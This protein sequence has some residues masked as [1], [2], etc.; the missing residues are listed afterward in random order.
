MPGRRPDLIVPIKDRRQHKRYLT[1]KNFGLLM[2]V[3]VVLFVI[4][5][6]RSEMRG[7]K[8]GDY[9]QLFGREAAVPIEQKPIE[10][11]REAP[12][13]VD[14]ATHADPMLVTPAAR[15]QWLQDDTATTTVAPVPAPVA[16][17]TADIRGGR[18]DVAVVG[19]P[20]GVAVV[21]TEKKKPLL[22]GGF[23]RN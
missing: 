21:R 13:P 6:V 18:A 5:T 16:V 1:L 10:V 7:L 14:D 12:P 22:S 4:I 20:D 19:G 8:P 17:T 15:A 23:G 2:I 3:L 9:G 11:V